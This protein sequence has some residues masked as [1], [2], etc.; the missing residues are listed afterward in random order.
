MELAIPGVALGLLY[1]VS[2][3]KKDEKS[4]E[5]FTN[6]LPNTNTPDKN[7]NEN[8]VEGLEEY[9]KTSSLS[10]LNKFDSQGVYTDKYFHS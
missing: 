7:Y 4:D 9:E 2:N 1:V 5:S 3:Q 8:N 10:R 6:Y